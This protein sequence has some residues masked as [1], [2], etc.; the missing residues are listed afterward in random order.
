[1]QLNVGRVL[2]CFRRGAVTSWSHAKMVAVRPFP[3]ME[4][5]DVSDS[6]WFVYDVG[7]V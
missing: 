4:L 1:M 7:G 3:N 2:I 5:L 6:Y